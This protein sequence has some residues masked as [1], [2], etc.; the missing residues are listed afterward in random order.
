MQVLLEGKVILYED[1]EAAKARVS[2]KLKK[3][4]KKRA[5]R[6]VADIGQMRNFYLYT[7]NNELQLHDLQKVCVEI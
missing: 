7:Q 2:G 4:G 5:R 6:S 3:P 1:P